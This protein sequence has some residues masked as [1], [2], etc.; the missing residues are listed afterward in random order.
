MRL[1]PSRMGLGAQLPDGKG[2]SGRTSGDLHASACHETAAL[3][4]PRPAAR[5]TTS[6]PARVAACTDDAHTSTGSLR[7]HG[8]VPRRCRNRLRGSRDRRLRG[9]LRRSSTGGSHLRWSEGGDVELHRMARW[10]KMLS[11]T[12]SP[13]FVACEIPPGCAVLRRLAKVAARRHGW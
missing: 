1:A 11:C 3:R 7:W 5:H 10:L 4:E 6:G 12:C 8:G 9:A 13:P 2:T